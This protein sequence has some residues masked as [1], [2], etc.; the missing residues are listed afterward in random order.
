MNIFL[1]PDE[2]T[3]KTAIDYFSRQNF[4]FSK[5]KLTILKGSGQESIYQYALT[6]SDGFSSI[7]KE[8]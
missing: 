6:K 1:Y 2:I 8:E 3:G 7:S 4:S 5:P